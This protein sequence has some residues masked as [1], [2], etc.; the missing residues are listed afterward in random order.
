MGLS[1]CRDRQRTCEVRNLLTARRKTTPVKVREKK[2]AQKRVRM[3]R[4]FAYAQHHLLRR[5]GIG[6]MKS[7][8]QRRGVDVRE[9]S[10]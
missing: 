6:P 7:Q 1:F 4:V 2:K 9:L 8:L 10:V 3:P 5:D